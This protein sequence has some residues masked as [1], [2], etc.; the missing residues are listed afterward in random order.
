MNREELIELL[1]KSNCKDVYC[2][3]EKLFMGIEEV[4]EEYGSLILVLRDPR[5]IETDKKELNNK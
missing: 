5:I 1:K 2:F 4:R 3:V